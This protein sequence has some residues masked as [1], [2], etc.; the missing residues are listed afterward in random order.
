[1]WNFIDG[2]FSS[3]LFGFE[4]GVVKVFSEVF[5]KRSGFQPKAKPTAVKKIR[6]RAIDKIEPFKQLK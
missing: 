1:M 4:R 3:R 2:L 6:Q 5:K